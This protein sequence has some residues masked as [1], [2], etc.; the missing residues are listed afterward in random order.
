MGYS[1]PIKDTRIRIWQKSNDVLITGQNIREEYW[2]G[3]K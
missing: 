2:I 3:K 1:N